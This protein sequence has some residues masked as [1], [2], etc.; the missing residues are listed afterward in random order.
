MTDVTFMIIMTALIFNRV[1][2]NAFL[3]LKFHQKTSQM[4]HRVKC[5]AIIKGIIDLYMIL[6][7]DY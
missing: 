2:S 6:I 1:L 4:S 5:K 7:G 3:N